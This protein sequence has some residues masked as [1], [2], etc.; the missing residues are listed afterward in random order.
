MIGPLL[1][2]GAEAMAA[3]SL[4]L[5]AREAAN[6]TLLALGAVAS[7][8]LGAVLLSA[9]AFIVLERHIDS[10]AACAILGMFWGALG[11]VYLATLN[12]RR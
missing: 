1:R 11:L 10:A 4:K 7:V 6:R 2:L 9:A 12:R 5:A 3:R 8:A